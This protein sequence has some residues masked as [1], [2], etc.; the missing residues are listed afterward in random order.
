MWPRRSRASSQRRPP[1][2]GR[3]KYVARSLR[4]C[5]A[6]FAAEEPASRRRYLEEHYQLNLSW[7][8]MVRMAPAPV[9]RPKSEC[10]PAGF[11]LGL[12]D[13]SAA[14]PAPVAPATGKHGSV[15]PTEL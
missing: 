1:E 4:T 3:D 14:F 12:Q 11:A 7:P 6:A 8:A 2:G 9:M 13:K 15:V 10:S 5:Q